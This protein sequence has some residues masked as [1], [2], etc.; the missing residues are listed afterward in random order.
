MLVIDSISRRCKNNP[1]HTLEDE[2]R[3]NN[4]RGIQ[5]TPCDRLEELEI[6]PKILQHV[7]NL[8]YTNVA[9][10]LLALGCCPPPGG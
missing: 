3:T 10:C 1:M 9:G 4:R 5:P 2:G 6:G 7:P 8:N